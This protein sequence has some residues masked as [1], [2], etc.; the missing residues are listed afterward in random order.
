[1]STLRA[2]TPRLSGDGCMDQPQRARAFDRWMGKGRPVWLIC[3]DIED[4][5]W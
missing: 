4:D 3:L 2:G 1:M 5:P